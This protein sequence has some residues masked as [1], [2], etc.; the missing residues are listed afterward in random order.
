MTITRSAALPQSHFW[1]TDL[2]RYAMRERVKAMRRREFITLLGSASAWIASLTVLSPPAWAQW[3]ADI[4]VR[5]VV[6]Y[7]AGGTG[8]VL[9]RLIAQDVSEK[10]GQP[11]RIDNR[12]GAGGIIGTEVVAHAA[13]DGTNLL[14]VANAFLINASL[15]MDLPYDPLTSFAPICTLA[16]SPMVFV[17]D[18]KSNYDSLSQFITAARD[19][20]NSLS[21]GATGPNTTQHLAVKALNQASHAHLQFVPFAGE[22]PA[23]DSLLGGHI[24]AVLGNYAGVKA[25]LDSE[26]RPLAVGSRE[27]LAQLPDV[28]TFSQAGF[29]KIDAVAWIGLV[30]PAKTPHR[31]VLEIASRFRSVLDASTIKS[32]L[33]AL[34]LTPI[35]L[36]NEEFGSFLREQQEWIARMVIR[37]ND[38]E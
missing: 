22:P 5:I 19:P 9:M 8:D 31:T 32:K 26:L 30:A 18:H 11:I 36:C 16:L 24:T 20:Q 3:P 15:K 12:P 7:P 29:D 4:S 35:T 10:S 14:M 38:N 37:Q 33:E 28:P 27:R 34:G 6:P 17:V 21:V 1:Y 25:Y 2:T 23:I 13:P